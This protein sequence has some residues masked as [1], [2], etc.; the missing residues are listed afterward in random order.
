MIEPA[1]LY[2]KSHVSKTHLFKR[3]LMR[4][5]LKDVEVLAVSKL[6]NSS[7]KQNSVLQLKAEVRPSS[8]YSLDFI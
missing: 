2:K 3:K 7:E 4:E 5:L 1:M 8:L 6:T